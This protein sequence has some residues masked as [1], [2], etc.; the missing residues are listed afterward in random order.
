[1]PF[2]ATWALVA[3]CNLLKVGCA[4]EPLTSVLAAGQAGLWGTSSKYLKTLN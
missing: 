4:N 2:D 3:M 1:M